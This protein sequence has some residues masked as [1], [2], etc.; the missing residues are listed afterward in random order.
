MTQN[1][2]YDGNTTR[3]G[4]FFQLFMAHQR[5][6]Y[7]Y[8]LAAVHNYSDTEDILQ[9]TATVMWRRFGEFQ[10]GTSFVA[11]G[12]AIARIQILKFFNEHKRSRIQ[13]D[14][15]LLEQINAVMLQETEQ[16]E[17]LT[18]AFRQCFRKLSDTHREVLTLRYKDGLAIKTIANKTGKSLYAMYKAFARIQDA[19]Q[20]CIEV[21]LRREGAI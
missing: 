12:I 6:L 11:W 7:A 16:M 9:E 15:E 4:L 17:G 8:I 2:N 5:N 20:R 14:D 19:L 13:F 21:T 3:E 10:Q 18:D 1:L